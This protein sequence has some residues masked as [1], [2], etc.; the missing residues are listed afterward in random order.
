MQNAKCK[1]KKY[2]W[3]N[4][5][6]CKSLVSCKLLTDISNLLA[7][8]SQLILHTLDKTVHI[9][10]IIGWTI[11]KFEYSWTWLYIPNFVLMIWWTY[12][13]LFYQQRYCFVGYD[14]FTLLWTV[15]DN[16]SG[17]NFLFGTPSAYWILGHCSLFL[18]LIPTKIFY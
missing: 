6:K 12:F 11:S 1:C 13:V 15:E 14:V 4:Y 3:G 17:C 16:F 9:L 18:S 10:N 8:S 2:N 7:E 5:S